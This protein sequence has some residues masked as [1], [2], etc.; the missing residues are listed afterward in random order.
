MVH[1]L[2]VELLGADA[3]E[4]YAHLRSLYFDRDVDFANEFAHFSILD[5]WDKQR[6]TVTGHRRTIFSVGPDTV[7]KPFSICHSSFTT[8][9]NC[10]CSYSSI[11]RFT[12]SGQ[13]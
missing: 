1:R 5:R 2:T 8:S 4:Y 6:P 11:L 3:V 10:S 13:G 12:S 9:R 7:R